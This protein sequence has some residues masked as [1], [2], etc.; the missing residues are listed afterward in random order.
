MV[1]RE[2]GT[3]GSEIGGMW[4]RRASEEIRKTVAE[5]AENS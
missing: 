5:P 1:H 2:W 3:E 4:K